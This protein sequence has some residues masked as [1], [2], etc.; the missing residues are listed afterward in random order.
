MNL[1]I[2]SDP[3]QTSEPAVCFSDL[4]ERIGELAIKAH[5]LTRRAEAHA[6]DAIDCGYDTDPTGSLHVSDSWNAANAA[7]GDLQQA[8]EEY[9]L[10]SNH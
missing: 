7:M 10:R 2:Q 3:P 5:N 8:I 6:E 4:L 1:E 9:N